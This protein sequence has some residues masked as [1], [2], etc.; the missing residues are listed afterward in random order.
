[1]PSESIKKI[2][3]VISL[4]TKTINNNNFLLISYT[5]HKVMVP[6][7]GIHIRSV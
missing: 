5:N 7:N 1:M 2:L 6:N 4:K 3:P